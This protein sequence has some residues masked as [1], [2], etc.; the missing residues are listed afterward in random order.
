M[1]NFIKYEYDSKIALESLRLNY[2][3]VFDD[4]FNNFDIDLLFE[5]NN[6]ILD[7]SKVGE[8]LFIFFVLSLVDVFSNAYIEFLKHNYKSVLRYRDSWNVD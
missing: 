4:L 6:D 1:E 8:Y 7:V 3:K 2:E 5:S